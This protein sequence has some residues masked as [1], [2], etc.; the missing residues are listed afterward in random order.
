[1][2]AYS[3]VPV[4]P[5]TVSHEVAWPHL[6]DS[7]DHALRLVVSFPKPTIISVKHSMLDKINEVTSI[8]RLWIVRTVCV[9][10]LVRGRAQ[11]EHG[12]MHDR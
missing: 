9:E 1:M 10:V 6:A 8:R 3:T 2:N 12:I 11:T 5:Q 7:P 4:A